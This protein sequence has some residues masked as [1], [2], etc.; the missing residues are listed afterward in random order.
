MT[1]YPARIAVDRSR[2]RAVSAVLAL[3]AMLAGPGAAVAQ[4]RTVADTSAEACAADYQR[5]CRGV[6]PGGGAIRACLEAHASELSA[7]CRAAAAPPGGLAAASDLD[8]GGEPGGRIAVPAGARVLRDIAYGP[9]PAQRMDVYLPVRP[10]AAPVLFMVHGGGWAIGDK[11]MAGVVSNKI[12]KWLPEGFIFISVNYRLLPNAD[13]LNQ[14]DDVA[15]ALAAAQAK[16]TSW[17]G[18]PA[19]FVLMGHSA[20]AHLVA[21]LA[22]DPTIATRQGATPWLGT[23]ALDSAALNVVEI[24]KARHYPLYDRAFGADP[25]VWHSASPLHRLT[26]TPRPMLLVCSSERTNACPQAQAYAIKAVG[27][28]GRVTVLPVALSHGAINKSLGLPGS[29]TANVNAFIRQLV[30]R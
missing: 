3:A 15:K 27:L 1:R 14:A 22:S 11:A 6:R 4:S 7:S 9:D 30:V 17:G 18:D 20:G 8:E 29:Y 13:P 5:F 25:A 12:A 24:M 10:Q 26:A 21:L 2:T 16:A 23:V 19:R 28:G